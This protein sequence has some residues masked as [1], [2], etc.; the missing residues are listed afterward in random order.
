[1]DEKVG[2]FML[3]HD[4]P[5]TVTFHVFVIF[6]DVK[7]CLPKL[8][9]RYRESGGSDRRVTNHLARVIGAGITT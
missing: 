7:L 2:M 6:D 8:Y 4:K 5:L 9:V 1:M 3:W